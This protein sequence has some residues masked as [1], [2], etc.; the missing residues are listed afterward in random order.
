MSETQYF[1]N[2]EVTS[3]AKAHIS[4]LD[5]GFTVA[6][7]VFE[8]LLITNGEVFALDRH[9]ERLANSA[10]GLGIICPDS[11]VVTEAV[12][13]TLLANSS[14]DHGRLRITVTS[15]N[16]PLG[17][18]RGGAQPTLVV[19]LAKT[20]RWPNTTSAVLIPW[21]KN[22]RS[23]L[24]G[25]KTTSYAENVMAL[26]LAHNLGFSEALMCDSQGRLSEGTGSNIFIVRDGELI[27]P[28]VHTGLLKGIT[29]DLVL[30]CAHTLGLK[31]SFADTAASQLA[32]ISEAFLTSSTRN[33]HPIT[34]LGT[35]DSSGKLEVTHEL[36]VGPITQRLSEA[37]QR[38]LESDINP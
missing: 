30:E 37:L 8:T 3:A 36:E 20:P 4:V 32:T 19:T 13:Q 2:G 33:V 38:I 26:E 25:L 24:V 5:H 27:T 18:D 9:L 16:G 28:G 15:G 22:E 21:I 17:S 11:S 7:G 35:C 10:R 12:R 6:D 34:E 1:V 31:V 29:R 23:P 14:I